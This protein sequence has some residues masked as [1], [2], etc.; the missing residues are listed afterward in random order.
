MIQTFMDT[1]GRRVLTVAQ[2]TTG[3]AAGAEPGAVQQQET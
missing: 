3:F 1:C 2:E